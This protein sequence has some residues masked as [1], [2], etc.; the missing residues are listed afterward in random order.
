MC[1]DEFFL[2]HALPLTMTILYAG[3]G[4]VTCSTCSLHFSK[5]CDNFLQKLV[6]EIRKCR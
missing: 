4:I 3:A 5:L 2:K 1:S 6:S